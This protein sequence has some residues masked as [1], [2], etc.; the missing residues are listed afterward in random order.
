MKPVTTSARVNTTWRGVSDNLILV[1]HMGRVGIG[2]GADL[3][4]GQFGQ[5]KH[6]IAFVGHRQGQRANKN[7]CLGCQY[8]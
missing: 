1:G 4:P 5:M 7:A 6:R 2:H 3:I 8:F